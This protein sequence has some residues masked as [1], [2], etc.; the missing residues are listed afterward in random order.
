MKLNIVKRPDG[1]F[2]LLPENDYDKV[3]KMQPGEILE[4]RAEKVRSPLN[5]RRFFAMLN[6]VY[7]NQN[8]FKNIDSMRRWLICK[9]GRFREY[10]APNGNKWYEH[11]SMN[12]ASMDEEA[13][14]KLKQDVAD[15]ALAELL[16]GMTQDELW[17]Q[18]EED[19][20]K[21]GYWH[22]E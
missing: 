12:Y 6:I 10:T 5:H 20:V 3:V 7:E 9:S 21:L 16:N 13:F 8:H 22:G 2:E 14:A 19:V 18:V 11:E 15:V 4:V 17:R 1:L